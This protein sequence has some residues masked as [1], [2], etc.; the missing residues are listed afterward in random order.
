M[1]CPVVRGLSLAATALL[2]SCGAQAGA[3]AAAAAGGRR[4]AAAAAGER[5]G[6]LRRPVRAPAAASTCARASPATCT[7]LGF[8]DGQNVAQGPG[9]VRQIDP[10]PYQAALDQ[11]KAQAAHAAAA[12]ADAKVELSARAGRCSPPTPPAS[13]TSTPAWP[14][15]A[16]AAADLAA[17]QAAERTAALNLGFTR[18]TAP[19]S[20]PRLRRQGRCPATWSP[21]DSTVLTSIVSLDPIRFRFTGPEAQ[22]L[23]YQREN[24]HRR[25]A[26]R[27]PP[28]QIRLQDE[29]DY[30][31]Q[32]RLDFVD[33]AFDTGSGRHPRPALVDNPGGFLDARHVRPHAAAGLAALHGPAGARPGGRH[34]PDPP[35]GLC[36]RRRT[37]RCAERVVEL[38]PLVDGP[39]RD[40]LGPRADR[41]GGDRRRAARPARPS[42]S[43]AAPGQIAARGRRRPTRA[44]PPPPSSSAT[45]ASRR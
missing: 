17:A 28:V 38:G 37:A 15:S 29:A 31:W 5:L 21:Q 10:R 11:A 13:R 42:R 43:T 20:G 26:R 18:V 34:R 24:L 3:R 36:G 7:A 35:G 8:K 1:F 25:A 16:Q 9:A 27:S 23:K 4:P 41:P 30:R 39:A 40:P 33:N 2:A 19:I 44:R 14:P 6:R 32:G 12:L 45:F 22:F